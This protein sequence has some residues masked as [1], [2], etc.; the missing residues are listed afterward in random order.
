MIVRSVSAVEKLAKPVDFKDVLKL[1]CWRRG[2]DSIGCGVA[3]KNTAE[4]WW[5][6]LTTLHNK[7]LDMNDQ[8]WH[9]MVSFHAFKVQIFWEGNIWKIAQNSILQIK[10]LK[11]WEVFQIFVVFLEYKNL[12]HF[13]DLKKDQY[14]FDKL[15]GRTFQSPLEVVCF[16]YLKFQPEEKFQPVKNEKE[17]CYQRFSKLSIF[18]LHQKISQI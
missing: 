12:S 15:F 14:W 6:V 10:H 9:W 11:Y 3:G 2:S 18:V 17:N 16:S 8:F 13:K 5:T 7:W 4:C 1:E